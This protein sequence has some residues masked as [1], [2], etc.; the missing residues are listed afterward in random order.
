MLLAFTAIASLLFAQTPRAAEVQL[1]RF[2]VFSARPIADVAFTPRP[3]TPPQKIVFYPTARSPRY[4]YRGAMPLRFV[5]V[6]TGTAVAEASIPPEIRDPLLLFAPVE[7][8]SAVG[9]LRYRI[10]VLDDSAARHGSGGLAI[11]NFS[12][13]ALAGTVNKET[14]TLKAGLNPTLAVGRSAKITLRTS[15][16]NRTYQSYADTV[17]LARNERALLI[18]FPPFYPGSL[19]VQ[20]RLLVDTPSGAG[21][22]KR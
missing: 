7:G 12:G 1:V 4:E 8:A 14:V 18:L 11:I 16:K 6:T 5:D 9:G 20:A 10:S 15:F 22:P 2:T 21:A 17:H 13:L 3:K 19:E